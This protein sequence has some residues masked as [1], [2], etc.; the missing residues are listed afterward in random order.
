VRKFTRQERSPVKSIVATLSIKRI[1]ESEIIKEIQ[2]QTNKTITT[3]FLYYVKEQIKKESSKWYC[4]LR[5]GEYE[6]IHEF[7]ERV[8]EVADLQRRHYKI[9]DDNA[10]NPGIQQAS[11]AALHKLNVT[12][13]KYYDIVPFL[14]AT[15]QKTQTLQNQSQIETE[16]R[17]TGIRMSPAGHYT[18][19]PLVENCQCILNGVDTDTVTHIECR[20]C[21]NIW[22]PRALGGQDWCPNPECV[23]GIKGNEFKPYDRIYDWVK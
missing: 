12:L 22:C 5:Q 14:T 18:R 10:N 4:Q 19:M 13:S 7:K 8:N 3:R 15:V 17:N 11:L 20:Y 23:H 9:I 16:T 1:P 21:L 6:Y 2:K